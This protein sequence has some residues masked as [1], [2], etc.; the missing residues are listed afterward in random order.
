MGRIDLTFE[1]KKSK[2]RR[3]RGCEKVRRGR[4]AV[5]EAGGQLVGGWADG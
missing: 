4:A 1:N 5:F 3:T 2:Q